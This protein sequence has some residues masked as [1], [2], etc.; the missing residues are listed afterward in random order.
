MVSP[1]G[2]LIAEL[3]SFLSV[4]QGLS[5]D[6][7]LVTECEQC[8]HSRLTSLNQRSDN[9]QVLYHVRGLC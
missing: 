4:K 9:Y 8:L 6:D 7:F 2:K 5:A 1:G 3:G